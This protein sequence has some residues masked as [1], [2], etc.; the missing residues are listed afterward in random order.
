MDRASTSTQSP[1]APASASEPDFKALFESGPG[2]YLILDPDLTIVAVSDAYLNAT[3]TKRL[4]ILGRNVFDV[5][6]DNPEDPETTGV[7]T[8][9]ASMERVKRD[10]VADTVAV[11]K[12]DIRRPESEGGGFEVRYWSPVNSPILRPSGKL[13][14]IFNRVEDVTEFVKR[15]ERGVAQELSADVLRERSTQ[16]EFELFE[17]A[18]ELQKLNS[19]LLAASK[20]KG[21]FL[22]NMSHELRTPLSAI[23]G[24]SELLLDDDGSRFKPDARKSF[25]GHINSGGQH[26]LG[27]IN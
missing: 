1:A 20:A 15:K 2:L 13:E 3:M 11:Q 23:I 4:E 14:Y 6:P 21:V 7:A 22:A 19:E 16:M 17:R 8:L 12:Y 18:Q 26:L 5:F 27:L 9:R 25:L 10:L 24:F